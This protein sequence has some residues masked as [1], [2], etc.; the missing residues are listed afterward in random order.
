MMKVRLLHVDVNATFINPTRNLLP[1]AL[2]RGCDTRFFGP[3]YVT[4]EVL[5]RGLAAFIATEGP[6][7]VISSNSLVLF[8]EKPT[9]SAYMKAVRKA[10]AFS[11]DENDL[12]Y[13]AIIAADFI[14][15]SIPR[16]VILLEN[17]FY[18]WTGRDIER[19]NQAGDFFI[20]FGEE[21]CPFVKDMPFLS[22]ERFAASATDMWAEFCRSQRHRVGSLLHFVADTELDV[23]PVSVRP[24]AWS[25]MGVQYHS[26]QVA[27]DTLIANGI[28]PV[29]DTRMRK[30][31]SLLKK[32]GLPGSERRFI[33]TLLNGDFAQRLRACRYSYTC[34]SA[35]DMPIRKFFE[36]PANGALLVCRP[37]HGFAAAGFED[38][39]NCVVS[40]PEALGAVNEKVEA[41]K[42]AFDSVAAA[43]Q[44]LIVGQHS[45]EA[46]AQHFAAI[47]GAIAEG[48]FF[49][50]FWDAGEHRL[51]SSRS[52]AASKDCEGSV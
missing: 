24:E 47:I 11:W 52:E 49:G 32:L 19:V 5:A 40:E 44:R 22:R 31:V 35:L 39:V 15:Q 38:G 36:I 48:R 29:I 2:A 13:L 16:L 50:S 28:Q 25:V 7:D 8:A 10:Y 45:V 37:F 3:G 41:A 23:T 21:F 20:G 33:Q 51:R 14:A 9:L 4:T 27:R 12:A 18:N 43:G 46:R 30:F 6:F 1:L 26:R 17:D 34:G 42:H